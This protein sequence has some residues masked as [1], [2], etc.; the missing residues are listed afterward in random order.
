[1]T[2]VEIFPFSGFLVLI[3]L[4]SERIF[5]LKR[6]GIKVSSETRSSSKTK[7]IL[8]PVFLLIL[9][10]FLFE[11]IKPVFQISFSILPETLTNPLADSL[12][13][14]IAGVLLIVIALGFLWLTLH[15]FK[16][17]LRFGLDEKTPGQLICSGVFSI[18]RNPFFLSLDLYFAGVVLVLTNL[19]FVGFAILVLVS[20]HFFILKE[21]KFMLKVYGEEYEKYT[22]N[23]RRYI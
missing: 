1:M 10:L 3:F 2:G 14:K 6:N 22:Q 7:V 19:F 13:L 9:L 21:E 20:I 16:K 15:H 4:I 5:Y 17:S 11:S 12:L 23:V 8:Y 18:S